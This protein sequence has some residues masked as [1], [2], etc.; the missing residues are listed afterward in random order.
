MTRKNKYNSE[1]IYNPLNP[2][3]WSLFR[4]VTVAISI[5]LFID[6]ILGFSIAS[7]KI[8][9]SYLAEIFPDNYFF[10]TFLPLLTIIGVIGL[11]SLQTKE[12]FDMSFYSAVFIKVLLHLGSTQFTL[13]GHYAGFALDTICSA[14]IIAIL[15][16]NIILEVSEPI[17]YA[18]ML[19]IGGILISFHLFLNYLSS[20]T[21]DQRLE[22]TWG[23]FYLLIIMIS[24]DLIIKKHVYFG[25]VL[26]LGIGI[27]NN[28]ILPFGLSGFEAGSEIILF[29][30]LF[31]FIHPI[32]YTDY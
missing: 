15:V 14:V 32:H 13:L 16:F 21:L 1:Y 9:Y 27:L 5:V 4:Q 6:W 29:I 18:D 3:N 28:Y 17:D 24:I 11:S 23:L 31:L 8:N 22:T 26:L 30:G 2:L 25:A 12:F 20:Q 10:I 19:S 7:E